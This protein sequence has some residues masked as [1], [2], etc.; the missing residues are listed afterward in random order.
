MNKIIL[1]NLSNGAFGN[2]FKDSELNV[3]KFTIINNSG[4]LTVSNINE[5]IFFNRFNILKK[6]I[7]KEVKKDEYLDM[8]NLTSYDFTSYDTI[9]DENILLQSIDTNYYD[10]NTLNLNFEITDT[11][12]YH[13]YTS[14]MLNRIDKYLLVSKLP[15]Y[16]HNLSSFINKNYFTTLENF[17]LIAKKLLKSLALL[18]HNN[19]LHGDLKST[20]ILINDYNDICLTDFGGVKIS[21]FDSY[22]LSCTITS[23]CPEDLEYEHDTKII[24]SNTNYKS[25]IWSLGLIFAEMILGYNPILRLYQK[26]NKNNVS[27]TVIE[28]NLLSYYKTIKFIQIKELVDANSLLQKYLDDKLTKQIYIIEKMLSIKPENRYN[29]VDEIY[30]ELFDENINLN[31][32][33]SYNY[34]YSNIIAKHQDYNFKLFY[35][36]RRN[37]YNTLLKVCNKLHILYLCPFIIDI[38]DRLFLRIIKKINDGIIEFGDF[39][40]KLIFA[41]V[42]ILA[43]GLINQRHPAY[44]SVLSNFNILNDMQNV[45]SLNKNLLDLLEI[46]QYDIYRPYNIFYCPYYLENQFC[47]CKNTKNIKNVNNEFS[48]IIHCGNEKLYLENYIKH[49]INNDIIGLSPN[50]YY[51]KLKLY[52][53]L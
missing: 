2:I 40:I 14:N 3:Y 31:F 45:G 8:D 23:R 46:L 41:G 12:I 26:L 24:F 22:Y 10:Y 37:N 49:I 53:K 4:V 48:F 52:D 5:L 20:N 17:E 39:E 42:I 16:L 1:N 50:D 38:L 29:T 25:D 28:K 51:E 19:I 11:K 18:H 21:N 32:K 43:T 36:I 7:Y 44:Y 15:F 33:I 35:D 13:K 30:K 34:D 9:F 27:E 6:N 47:K